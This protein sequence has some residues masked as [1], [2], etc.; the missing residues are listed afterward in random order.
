MN[1]ICVNLL[2][3][4]LLLF[5]VQNLLNL[6]RF[7]NHL[8]FFHNNIQNKKLKLIYNEF[9]ESKDLL[10]FLDIRHNLQKLIQQFYS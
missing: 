7:D 5:F 2:T 1:G 3:G 8:I 10:N 4:F 9:N 6:I